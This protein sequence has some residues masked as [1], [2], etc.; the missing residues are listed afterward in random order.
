MDHGPVGKLGAVLDRLHTEDGPPFLQERVQEKL[1][2]LIDPWL[3]IKR[4]HEGTQKVRRVEHADPL[5]PPTTST[6]EDGTFEAL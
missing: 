2:L 5:Q 3:P 1:R 4:H 6:I